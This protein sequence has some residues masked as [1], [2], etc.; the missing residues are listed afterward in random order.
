M[1]QAF[2]GSVGAQTQSCSGTSRISAPELFR[3]IRIR[4]AAEL[5]AGNNRLYSG[6]VRRIPLGL[7]LPRPRLGSKAMAM[8]AG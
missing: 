6:V 1:I 2:A 7:S 8:Q 5:E 4:M 3:P